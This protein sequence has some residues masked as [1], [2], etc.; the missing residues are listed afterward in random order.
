MYDYVIV[1]AGFTGATCAQVLTERGKRCIVVDKRSHVGGN[2]YTEN[3]NGINVHMYGPH[4]FHTSSEKIWSYVNR[5]SKFNH[6][7]NRPKVICDDGVYSF[8][9][10]MMTLH[11]LWGVKTPSEAQK[12]LE[13]ETQPYKKGEPKN[14]EEYALSQIGK[15]LYE[16]FVYG[17]TK[18]QWQ[19]DPRCLPASILKRIPVRL[20]WDDNYYNDSYQGI[21]VHGYTSIFN[22]MLQN[23]EVKLNFDFLDD[24]RSLES[25]SKKIIYTGPIDA[26]HGYVHG[27]LDYRTLKFVHN[28]L[29]G[30]V[31]GNA[32]MNYSSLSVPWTRQIEHKHFDMKPEL[33]HTVVTQEI[34]L[35]WSVG[36]EPY[37]PI[38][39]E[40]NTKLHHKYV[41]MTQKNYVIAGRLGRYQY[42]D[43]HQAIGMGLSIA[44]E[45]TR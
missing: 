38:N 19:I 44:D 14:L 30:D 28:K 11:Q 42:Y 9:I 3:W 18:K 15:E 29:Q 41:N 7:V 23:V 34:P 40:A 17:Y 33:S 45:E 12:K 36:S 4:I 32:Q 2:C 25:L 22:C 10:N 39:D 37:Y 1:G 6:F 13:T 24:Q 31:Q 35:S 26:L 27:A 16:R 20:T 21:P 5:F 43:M 8:P